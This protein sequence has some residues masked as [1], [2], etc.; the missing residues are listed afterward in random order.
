MPALYLIDGSFELFRCY[1]GAPKVQR[2]DGHE[3]GA[4]RGFYQTMASLLRD[5]AVTHAAIAFD[6][7]PSLQ[8]R[9]E[10]D[11]KLIHAQ[12]DMALEVSRAL[13]ITLWPMTTHV[14]ADDALATAA[15]RF[16][17]DSALN[18]IV[19][20][21]SD[22][23]FAQCVRGQRVVVLNR[24]KNI[25]TDESGV[26]E[27]FGVLPERIPEYFALVGDKSDGIPGVPGFGKKS[28][29]AVIQRYGRME[30][31]P[32]SGELWDVEVRGLPKLVDMFVERRQEA[33]LYR[34]LSIR[35]LQVPLPD[36]LEDLQW[37]GAN[38][39][40][41]EELSRQLADPGIL[42]RTLRKWDDGV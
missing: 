5:P 13:G 16:A 17:D 29:A 11:T 14:Q 32:A 36:T 28:A 6:S 37:C 15:H 33:L 10:S 22:N 2:S 20:C 35:N 27:K 24:I 42:E 3:V 8:A 39:G 7:M 31:F 34:N 26:L 9:D 18:E 23:D 30:D 12:Y 19:I 38:R 1:Y 25:R 21:S 40:K 4:A 41:V